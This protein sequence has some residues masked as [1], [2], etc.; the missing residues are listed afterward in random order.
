[1][2]VLIVTVSRKKGAHLVNTEYRFV[3]VCLR[4][5]LEH[6][7]KINTYKTEERFNVKKKFRFFNKSKVKYQIEVDNDNV[8]NQCIVAMEDDTWLWKKIKNDDI[9]ALLQSYYF[10]NYI[11]LDN[12]SRRKI[13]IESPYYDR[14]G[15]RKFEA[16]NIE[17]LLPQPYFYEAVP[18]SRSKIKKYSGVM[19]VRLLTEMFN[20][21]NKNI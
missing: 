9:P 10:I 16:A 17:K 19:R 7:D 21:L 1:M 15:T 4:R 18:M 3:S 12:P 6:I 14:L 11:S 8:H 20:N 13:F 2:Y 5:I